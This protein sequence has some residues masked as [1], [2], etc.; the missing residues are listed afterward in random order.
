MYN[1]GSIS[2]ESL[3]NVYLNNFDKSKDK[4]E[5]EIEGAINS[6]RSELSGLAYLKEKYKDHDNPEMFGRYI[7]VADSAKKLRLIASYGSFYNI[8]NRKG[9]LYLS[10]KYKEYDPNHF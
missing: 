7:S 5:E 10:E 2:K 3:Y 8:S 1:K 9:V 4:I 6:I